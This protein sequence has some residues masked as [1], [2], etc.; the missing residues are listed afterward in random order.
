MEWILHQKSVMPLR[1]VVG[2]FPDFDAA[3]EARSELL[4]AGVARHRIQVRRLEL[5]D[6]MA[7]SDPDEVAGCELSVVSEPRD[8]DRFSQLMARNG[9]RRTLLRR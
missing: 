7:V 8:W 5:E 1:T 6:A 3:E 2:Y 4:E 9:A